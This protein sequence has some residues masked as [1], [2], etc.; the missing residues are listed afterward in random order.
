M[1][2]PNL[3]KPLELQMLTLNC[4]YKNLNKFYLPFFSVFILL[5][6]ISYMPEL[7]G[8]LTPNCTWVAANINKGLLFVLRLDP[9]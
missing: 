5:Q 2:E 9:G 3:G 6:S 8:F 7:F 4:F 1:V